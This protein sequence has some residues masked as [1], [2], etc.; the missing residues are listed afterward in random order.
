[1]NV[2]SYNF[3]AHDNKV[4]NS[5]TI[6][7]GSCNNQLSIGDNVYLRASKSVEINGVFTVPVGAE[8]YID[9]NPCY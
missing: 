5:I 8:L 4:K 6:G 2:C 9:T 1:M 7:N 3:S